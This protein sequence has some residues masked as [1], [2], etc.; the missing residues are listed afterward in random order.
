[1]GD[2]S[3]M[4]V[5]NRVRERRKS[6]GFTM[7]QLAER[8]GVSSLTIHRVEMDKVSPS[9]ALLS[10]IAECLGQPIS[11]FFEDGRLTIV[12]AGTAPMIESGKLKLR[13]LAPKGLI[14]DDLS[15]SF[16]ESQQGEFVSKHTHNGF[17][18]TYV[19]KGK[20]LFRYGP[21]EYPLNTGDLIYFDGSVPHSVM[22][23]EPVQFISIYFRKKTRKGRR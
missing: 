18:L 7:K 6:L 12:K 11:D 9:V 15:V 14:E 3:G 13:L 8:V 21:K 17:E 10:K 19:I 5:G 4:N 1:V 2:Y 23:S 22:A 20:N 16:G